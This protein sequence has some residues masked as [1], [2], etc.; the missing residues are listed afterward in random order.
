MRNISVISLSQ[1]RRLIQS[2]RILNRRA[3]STAAYV[4][5]E[6]EVS[7]RRKAEGIEGRRPPIYVAATRQ[8]VGKTTT[9]LAVM[10][11]LM[12][13][14]EKVGFMKPVGQKCLMVRDEFG[15]EV[16]VDK[17]VAVVRQH[18]HL[19]HC[20]YHNMSPVRIL[21]GYTKNYID[22]KLS[23]EEQ[24]QTILDAYRAIDDCSDVVLCEGTGHCAVGSIVGAS[25]A[26]VAQWLGAKMVRLHC[27]V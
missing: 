23:N 3:L 27:V 10:S 6:V 1:R 19:N 26:R 7:P 9:S 13:R 5:E 22:G 11:G 20:A 24:L 14:F 2:A 25:N 4:T 15:K 17:D 8:H 16:E 18:F 12:K 21:P